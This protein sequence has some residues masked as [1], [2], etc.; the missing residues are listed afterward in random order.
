MKIV[1]IGAKIMML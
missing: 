1:A